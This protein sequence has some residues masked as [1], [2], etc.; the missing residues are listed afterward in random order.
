MFKLIE[1]FTT[2]VKK[3]Q[4]NLSIF[5]FKAFKVREQYIFR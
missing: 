2:G 1:H 5:V 3:M 4:S